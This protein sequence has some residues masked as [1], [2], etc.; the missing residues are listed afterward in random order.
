MDPEVQREAEALY[1]RAIA[2]DP[3]LAIAMT[4]LGNVL[5]KRGEEHEAE[6]LYRSAIEI[7]EKIPEA[8]YNLGYIALERGCAADALTS[9]RRSLEIDP[10][11]A[12]AHYNAAV[13]CEQLTMRRP[14]KIHWKGYLDLVSTG[15]W[16]DH[17]RK[18]LAGKI[19]RHPF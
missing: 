12:D 5:Y 1:R 7:D 19:V 11:F 2:L 3:T 15:P 17:A 8:H 16:A 4:N 18:A 10:K 6:A 13:A 14:A 9:F